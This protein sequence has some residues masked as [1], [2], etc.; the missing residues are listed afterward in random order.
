M[1]FAP[2]L[3]AGTAE[4]YARYR[5]PYPQSMIDELRTRAGLTGEGTLL[6]LACGPGKVALPLAPYVAEVVAVDQ[7]P[8]MIEVGRQLAESQGIR[9]VR[10]QVGRAEDLAFPAGSLTIVTVGNA[11]HRLDQPLV[12]ERVKE[13]LTPEGCLALLYTGGFGWGTEAWKQIV[14]GVVEKWADPPSSRGAAAP[15]QTLSHEDVL[16]AAGFREVDK[17]EF[18]VPHV[19][20][21]DEIIGHTYST[22]FASRAAFGDRLEAFETDLRRALLAYGESGEYAEELSFAYTFARGVR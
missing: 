3:Y 21:I 12:A 20:T 2:D 15:P 14:V 4:F 6:D 5:V 1:D 17:R 8:D 19:W 11:F 16:R 9:N 18:L 13:W 22:S 10:W 7:E